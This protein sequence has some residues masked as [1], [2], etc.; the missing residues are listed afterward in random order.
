VEFNS[1]PLYLDIFNFTVSKYTD[2]ELDFYFSL[3]MFFKLLVIN[4]LVSWISL[5]CAK[6]KE[7]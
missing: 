3:N 1:E 4:V 7:R 2:K 5:A 6:L